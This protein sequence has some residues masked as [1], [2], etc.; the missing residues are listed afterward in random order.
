MNV[1][2]HAAP[3]G[4][5]IKFVVR[6]SKQS[7]PW[8]ALILPFGLE[9]EPAARLVESL[10]EDFRVL[11]WVSRLILAP[12]N[13]EVVADDLTVDKH[14]GDMLSLL[15]TVVGP[16]QIDLIGY[17]SGAG[18]ALAAANRVP[19]R[20]RKLILVNGEFLLLDE[21]R[22]LTA[23]AKDVDQLL[24]LAAQSM[25]HARKVFALI[26]QASHVVPESDAPVSVSV[27]YSNPVYL[28]RYA[29]NYLSYRATDFRELARSMDHETLVM[30]G[31]GD[32][33]TN[34]NS[35]TVIHRELAHSRLHVERD[36]NHYELLKVSA[37]YLHVIRS[38]LGD[39][40]PAPAEKCRGQ[41]A[42]PPIC[43]IDNDS[44]IHRVF[45]RQAGLN[46]GKTASIIAGTSLS[47]GQLNARA[48]FLAAYLIEQGVTP[49]DSV[50]ISIHRSHEMLVA[51]LAILKCGAA[52]LPFDRNDPVSHTLSC[53]DKADAHIVILDYESLDLAKSR[54]IM[55]HT[56]TPGLFGS[57]RQDNIVAHATAES[58]AYILFTSGSTGQPKGVVVPHR[59]VVRLVKDANYVDIGARDC[60]LQFAPVSFDASTFEIWGALL[61]GASLVLYSGSI[62]D[63]NLLSREISDNKVTVLWLTAA[64]F[65]LVGTRYVSMLRPL[66]TLLAG[67]DVLNP[68]VV[69][70]VLDAHPGLILI[71][72]YGP[73]ENTTFTCCHRMSN[74]TRPHT[75]VPIGKPITGTDI[76]ILD[77]NRDPVQIGQI[78]ELYVSGNGVALGYLE[79]ADTFFFDST[80]AKGL[81]YRTGDLVMET[82]NG[83][84]EFIGRTDNEV[85]IRGYRVSVEHVE[86]SLM[87]LSQVDSVA[88][89]PKK[90]SISEHHLIAY[91]QPKPN[92]EITPEQIKRALSNVV[93]PYMVPDVIEICSTLPISKNGKINRAQLSEMAHYR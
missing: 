66:R 39:R 82:P 15:N 77:V 93:P 1:Q 2:Y 53:L 52:Y 76:H 10:A 3:G 54:L 30:S 42:S 81:I 29:L 6:D 89:V 23:Q 56:A 58:R 90:S 40:S 36:G 67:G 86:N 11:S 19:E 35:A 41:G 37:S 45:E 51:M 31:D 33:Q 48:N 75:T 13:Q 73:T 4:T 64:L 65:H 62:L 34:V 28:H 38:F 32:E 83:D 16:E 44:L 61:N 84:M 70:T 74:E 60:F 47:Y 72:G 50:A 63:P 69:N 87:Q 55:I 25:D 27:P 21:P 22:C 14:V 17:C 71:N 91:L 80:I 43:D 59:A 79:D 49:G 26:Q 7:K 46:P 5:N 88:V 68:E 85:K 78:G 9:L 18:I 12:Q 92:I 8:I 57:E 20:F 24:P